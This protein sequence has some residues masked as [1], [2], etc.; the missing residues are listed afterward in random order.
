M[1]AQTTSEP[2]ISVLV[3]DDHQMVLESL[4]RLLSDEAGIAVVGTAATGAEA[5]AEAARLQP[6][7]VVMDYVLPDM[8][9]V[10]AAAQAQVAAPTAR[11]VILTGSDVDE[12][13][14]AAAASGCDAYM[15]KTRAVSELARVIRFVHAG[16]TMFPEG[17]L[18]HLPKIDD[19]RVHYQPVVRLEGQDVVGFEALVR[20]QHPE[21]GLLLP[22]EFIDLAERT[23]FIVE[24]GHFV[25]ATACEQAM[26]WR[27]RYRA[28]PPIHMS[29]NVS[30]VEFRQAGFVDRVHGTLLESGVDPSTMAVEITET[31]LLE[32]DS[33]NLGRLH[34]LRGL[35]LRIALDDFGTGYSSLSYLRRFPIDVIKV[36][37]SFTDGIPGLDRTASVMNAISNLAVEMGAASQAEGIE[38]SEQA[39]ILRDMGWD[40]GQGFHFARALDEGA[41]EAYLDARLPIR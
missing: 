10:A 27:R 41:A 17:Q 6:D 21:R 18:A 38:R 39:A 35:G 2:A 34:E 32:D 5:V 23:G 29:F 19:L 1:G 9:G 25:M 24:L 7:V 37:K 13:P 20:W 26:R 8:D 30:G 31:V 12:A 33:T 3:V 4:V 11:V 14:F 22:V 28:D 16:G 36:D 40:L 15:E